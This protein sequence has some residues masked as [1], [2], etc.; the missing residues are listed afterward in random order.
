MN[1]RTNQKG[2]TIVELLIVIVVIAILAAISIVAY[3]GIQQRARN[4]QA[5]NLASQVA[6]KAEVYYAI[7][8]SYPTAAAHFAGEAALEGLKVTIRTGAPVATPINTTFNS[9]ATPLTQ[10][11]AYNRVVYTGG[12]TG[13]DI[14]YLQ[15]STVTTLSKGTAPSG[16]ATFV[17]NENI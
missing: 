3:T 11:E 9:V 4:S 10:Y 12:A 13:Y 14:K 16:A 8:G 7:N 17:S 6:K 15:S 1:L 5:L 2:F